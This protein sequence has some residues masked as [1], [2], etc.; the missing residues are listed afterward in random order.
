MAFVLNP[1]VTEG[2]PPLTG[3]PCADLARA[4]A[5]LARTARRERF[6]RRWVG[7][8]GI[9][10]FNLVTLLIQGFG[11]G[12]WKEAGISS[13]LGVAVGEVMVVTQPTKA[14]HT[15]RQQ[16]RVFVLKVGFAF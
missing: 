4:G 12:E 9:V 14:L 5:V 1:L 11:W 16:G 3:D 10:G 6:G 15:F 7:H 8:A 13:V 2:P